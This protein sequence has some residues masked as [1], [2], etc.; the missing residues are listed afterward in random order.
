MARHYFL[1][2]NTPVGFYSY[3]DYLIDAEKAKKVYVIKGGPGTGKSTLMKAA[4]NW[5]EENGYDVDYLHCSSDPNSLDGVIIDGDIAMVDG[6]SPHIVDPKNPG[7]V[8]TII[9]MGDFWD[10]GRLRENKEKIIGINKQIKEYFASAY[11]YLAA[12][13]NIYKNIPEPGEKKLAGNTAKTIFEETAGRESSCGSGRT[14]KLFATAIGPKGVL[15][16]ADTLALKKCY[17]LKTDFSKGTSGIMQALVQIFNDNGYDTEIFYDPLAPDKL[18]E[19][20]CVPEVNL[21]VITSRGYGSITSR[22]AYVIDIDEIMEINTCGKEYIH[23]TLIT[24]MLVK[25]AAATI[26]K[27]K[28]KHDELEQCY[29]PCMD[30]ESANKNAARIIE[31]IRNNKT[32]AKGI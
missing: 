5:G 19:H 2:G 27:A 9:N 31:D 10:E 18:I 22:D 23:N 28:K 30:F 32:Q 13:G 17:I 1:G 20:I 16:F 4:A 7:C 24:E 8:E 12:A 14:R 21:S 29:I 15:S 11:N 26:A 3:Y 25:E 6:T